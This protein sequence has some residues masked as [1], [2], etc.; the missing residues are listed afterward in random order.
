MILSEMDKQYLLRGLNALS[1]AGEH[2]YFADGH[3]GAAMIAAVFLC[4]ENAMDAGTD[5]VIRA[6]M[7]EHWTNTDLFAPL[8]H[9]EPDPEG[10]ERILSTME[11]TMDCLREA[12]H[13]V[14]L[15]TMGLRAFQAL[16]EAI[17]PGR[18]AG[19]C[20]MIKQF[21]PTPDLELGPGDEAYHLDDA[22]SHAE[23]ALSEL[24]RTMR[25][26]EGR[27]QGWS[28][29]LLTY[30]RAL[31]DLK[32]M[33]YAHTARQAEKGFSLYLKRG[34][35]GPLETDKAR[36]EHEQKPQRPLGKTYWENRRNRSIEIGHLFKYPYGFYG[37]LA[38]AGDAELK[39]RC[40]EE[41][42]RIF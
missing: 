31:M 33:G 27:G 16:P 13:N 30:A 32:E 21:K 3:R 18:V 23:F 29:H 36:P 20:R 22:Q 5:A 15:P 14:I 26:F 7:D 11:K 9:E 2:D 1:R 6:I 17:T 12:G 37:L 10:L 38:G 28:G 19:I 42:W 39:A 41:T 4:R 35:I 8:S 24:R 25:V 40:L 34:R